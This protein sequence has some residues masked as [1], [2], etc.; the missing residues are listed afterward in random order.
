M[1]LVKLDNVYKSFLDVKHPTLRTVFSRKQKR[2][3][4]LKDMSFEVE[5]GEFLGVLGKNGVGKST[6]LRLIGGIYEKDSGSIIT[7]GDITS[8]FEFGS[9]FNPEL[10]G[11]KFCTEF[12]RFKGV[13]GKEIKELTEDIHEFSELG[14]FFYEP[15]KK[16]SSGMQA[17]LIFS[18]S[19]ALP[20][21]IIL[22]DEFLIVGDEYFQGKAW[23]RLQ[24]FLSKGAT[25]IIVTH[26]W[27]SVLKLCKRSMILSHDGI[28]FIGETYKTVQ[29]YRGFKHLESG[30]LSFKDT[31]R[32]TRE[33]VFA[34]SGEQF[35][36][37]FHVK[38]FDDFK[39]DAFRVSFSIERHIE[40]IGWS[41]AMIGG[42]NIEG[43]F[44][45]REFNLNLLIEDFFLA[46][47]EYLMCLFLTTPLKKNQIAV[48]RIYS[49]LT[50][51]NGN[52]IKLIVRGENNS[53]QLI[54]KQL[55]WK[56][57]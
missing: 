52:P 57:I 45:K 46:P 14:E 16:Y 37:N 17:K 36:Y 23:K 41:L 22:I 40:G 43:I 28:E 24:E 39:E 33:T 13:N 48:D 1:E 55:E 5:A 35:N 15:I 21:K 30:E 6:L 12:F 42:S 20:T 49:S 34:T 31:D 25:G 32:M 7:K 54:K 50:W 47:G 3:I 4:V 8:I 2:I 26:D 56:I 51:L 29:K 10:T 9:I 18:V 11:E 38:A 19:T 53:G 27:T 44:G